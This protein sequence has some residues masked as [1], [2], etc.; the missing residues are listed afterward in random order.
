MPHAKD[1]KGAKVGKLCLLC[2]LRVLGVRQKWYGKI[3]VGNPPGIFGAA[4]VVK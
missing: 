3:H 1:A 4:T 2:A